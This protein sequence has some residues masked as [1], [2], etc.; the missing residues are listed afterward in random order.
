[1]RYWRPWRRFLIFIVGL[2]P[3]RFDGLKEWVCGYLYPMDSVL[4]FS[5]EA[6]KEET[7]E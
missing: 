6:A 1:M 5:E 2:I 4:C 7:K 3:Y